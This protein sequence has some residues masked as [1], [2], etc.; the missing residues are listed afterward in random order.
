MFKNDLFTIKISTAFAAGGI[1]L[2]REWKK[3]E[4]ENNLLVEE[5]LGIELQLLTDVTQEFG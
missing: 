4:K 3:K 2:F 1:K 5:N